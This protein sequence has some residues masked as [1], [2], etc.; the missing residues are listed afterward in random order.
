MP[1]AHVWRSASPFNIRPPIRSRSLRD[2]QP[3]READGSLLLRPAGHGALLQ[4]LQ[5]LDADLVVIKNIDNI[6]PF[7]R[8]DEVVYWKR[9]LIG[10]ATELQRDRPPDRPVRVC[11]VVRNEGEPGGA[12]FWVIGRDGRTSPQIV[13]A[14]QV[15]LSDPDA[16]AH[17]H[18]RDPL[19]P[20]RS[21]LRGTCARWAPIRSAA[22][23]RSIRGL[24]SNKSHAGRDLIASSGPGLWN[25]A[26][27][28]WH[29]VFV[30]V[31][32]STFAPVKT[33][34]DLLRPAH[35]SL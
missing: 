27:A 6:V 22:V 26:M 9:V 8:S 14:S 2:G 12:P 18:G 16:A 20:G 15:D 13:E 25:G 3:V 1:R 30:E 33:V 17:L 10:Y 29:T 32:A 31:P 28:G 21:R 11:G 4:N 35:Q 19:Q 24:H 34:F 5:A 7:E 23:R